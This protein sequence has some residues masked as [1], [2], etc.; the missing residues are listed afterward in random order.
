MESV[1]Q[2][3]AKATPFEALKGDV[4]TEV[5]VIGGGM[6]GVLTAYF[7]DKAGVD[8]ILVE[9]KRIGNGITKNT[10]AKITSQHGFIYNDLLGRFGEEKAQMYLKA[11]EWALNK[12]RDL[13][14]NIDCDFEEK[15][16][17]V[18]SVS[19]CGK[20]QAEITALE[21]IGFHADYFENL[22]LPFDIAGAVRFKNQAQFNPLKFLYEISKG[23]KIYENTTVR[24]LSEHTAVCDNGKIKANKIIVATHFPLNNKHGAYWLKL[25]QHRSYVIALE[26]AADV[27]GMYVDDDEKGMSFR[28]YN[29]LLFVGG[30][31]HR[32]GKQGGNWRELRSFAKLNYPQAKEK[33]HWATQDCMSLDGVPYIGNYSKATP[34]FYVAS[35]FN[36]WGMTS[37]MVAA[38]ILCDTIIGQKN[39]YAPVFYPSRTIFRPQLA[40]N[41]FEAV[42][43]LLTPTPKRCSHLGCALKWNNAEQTWDCAC[44]GSRFTENGKLIDN[45]STSNAKWSGGD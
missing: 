28:N 41:G 38:R 24:E 42:I 37:S 18:Y 13:C 22:P 11:N 44:H 34:D 43:N 32:T 19:N 10:T 31:S 40:V 5:L 45:P 12:Y 7:L 1:W 36:K 4:E 35:G 25:Y 30:G 33:F 21:K 16:S 26:N 14:K 23:L 15:D 6:A 39:P 9:A 20:A 3:T 27:G 29:G 2:K 8:Y 17:F